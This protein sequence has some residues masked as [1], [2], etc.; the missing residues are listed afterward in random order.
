MFILS[1]EFTSLEPAAGVHRHSAN[2]G[3]LHGRPGRSLLANMHSLEE[4]KE[5]EDYCSVIES[6]LLKITGV[7]IY[8][9]MS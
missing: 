3:D 4:E 7:Y 8:R 6:L 9:V 1:I 5:E 2:R